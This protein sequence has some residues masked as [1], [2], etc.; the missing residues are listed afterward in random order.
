MNNE[1][2]MK[3]EAAKWLLDLHFY[4]CSQV[5]YLIQECEQHVPDI[6]RVVGGWLFKQLPET[7]YDLV[8]HVL[9]QSLINV[10]RV[11]KLD[12][13]KNDPLIQPQKVSPS[14]KNKYDYRFIF[15]FFPGY[16]LQ[17]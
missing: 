5:S 4:Q 13:C 1:E 9:P 12:V 8:E 3:R 11:G 7:L 16:I 2:K 15:F 17:A 6:I 10:L 14:R